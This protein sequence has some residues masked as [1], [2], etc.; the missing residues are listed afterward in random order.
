MWLQ[1]DL[2]SAVLE[3]NNFHGS[4][5]CCEDRGLT[6][7]QVATRPTRISKHWH[8]PVLVNLPHLEYA[9]TCDAYAPL[10]ESPLVSCFPAH[11]TARASR[12]SARTGRYISFPPG[13]R[14]HEQL[15]CDC[16]SGI[17]RFAKNYI[18]GG[19]RRQF[20]FWRSSGLRASTNRHSV[21]PRMKLSVKDNSPGLAR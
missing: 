11:R 7:N 1:R 19:I 20:Y 5:G 2:E 10:R 9:N 17:V 18:C 13:N 3:G 6:V 14:T 12:V 16:Y 15:R 8:L 21:P 4:C